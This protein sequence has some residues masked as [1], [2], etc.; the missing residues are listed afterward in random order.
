[1][2][3]GVLDNVVEMKEWLIRRHTV[4]EQVDH[5]KEEWKLVV[6]VLDRVFFSSLCLM[7]FVFCSG[8][9]FNIPSYGDVVV[10]GELV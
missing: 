8:L 5:N 2:L 10:E 1:M 3:S 4:V 9:F 7:V 6:Y